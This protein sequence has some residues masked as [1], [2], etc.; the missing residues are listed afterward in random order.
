MIIYMYVLL[1]CHKYFFITVCTEKKLYW[2]CIY[3]NFFVGR[4]EIVDICA[5]ISAMHMVSRK[6]MTNFSHKLIDKDHFE[7][8]P[9]GL[10]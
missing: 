3:I 8:W 4:K 2:F 7:E 9:S 5:S 10:P 1:H 6:M